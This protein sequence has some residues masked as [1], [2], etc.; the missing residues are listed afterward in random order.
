MPCPSTHLPNE[1]WIEIF[2][3]ATIC[4]TLSV[5]ATSYE[6]FCNS[7]SPEADKVLRTKRTLA[8]VC[9]EWYALSQEFLYSD[10][11]I[12]RSQSSLKSVLSR[13][14][15]NSN[16]KFVRR[17]VL[18]Y[19]STTTPTY[20]PDP[21]PSVE[22]LKLCNQVEVLVRP[23]LF[24]TIPTQNLP[25]DIPRFEFDADCTPL[26]TLK[27]LDWNYNFEAER[28]GGINSLNVV[29]R[30]APNLQYLFLGNFTDRTYTTTSQ[31]IQL[32]KLQTLS[33]ST[34]SAQILYQL[35]YR[36]SLPSLTNVIIGALYIH[37]IETLWEK[38]GEQLKSVE[39]GRHVGFLMG[40]HLGPCLQ[41]CPNLEELNYYIFFTLPPMFTDTHH[42]IISVGLHA[43]PNMMVEDEG[44]WRLLENHFSALLDGALP[45]LRRVRLYGDWEHILHDK[46]F[47]SSYAKLQEGYAVYICP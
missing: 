15:S 47:A 25:V 41:A 40:D 44:M 2:E 16:A 32:P 5:F 12:G 39:L 34:I 19:Q 31:P 28:T 45:G 35:A 46:R 27:R 1:L 42:S 9:R 14:E 7:Q 17:V 6:P 3:W 4:P 21:L 30:N 23:R 24:S 37:S 13:Q 18:P 38:Y 33:L 20:T 36:W 11:R 8:L 22:I 10:V 26:P 29:L 43:S